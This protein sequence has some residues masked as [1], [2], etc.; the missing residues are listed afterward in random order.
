MN[1][2]K[3]AIEK[4]EKKNLHDEIANAG[5][6]GALFGGVLAANT[7]VT[8][9]T[10]D[11]IDKSNLSPK[12]K[13]IAYGINLGMYVAVTAV[14]KSLY[15]KSQERAYYFTNSIVETANKGILDECEEET[16]GYFR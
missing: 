6:S 8:W 4:L 3:V 5:I 11:L 1:D 15:R 7:A 13:L 10:I 14:T 9:H 12:K 16:N 2:S